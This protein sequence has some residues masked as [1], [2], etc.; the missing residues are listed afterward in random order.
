MPGVQEA[1]RALDA[2]HVDLVIT[3]LRMPKVSGLDLVR[4]VRENHADMEVIM[5]TGYAS[6]PGAVE[7]MQTGAHEYLAKPFTDAELLAATRRA[8]DRLRLR[9]P[10]AQ[11]ASYCFWRS[12][13]DTAMADTSYRLF[14]TPVA[15]WRAFSR[16][17]R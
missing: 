8:I 3:D 17:S 4:H 14:S 11:R 6:V 16:C 9:R 2:T 1:I 12:S 13:S 7:A 5:V 15:D 10:V